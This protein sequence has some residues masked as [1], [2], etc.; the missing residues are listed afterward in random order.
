MCLCRIFEVF[1]YNVQ[2]CKMKKQKTLP[3][4]QK[5][6]ILAILVDLIWDLSNSKAC[7]SHSPWSDTFI[8]HTIR[9]RDNIWFFHSIQ[10]HNDTIFWPQK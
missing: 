6:K 7:W 1:F 2:G 4:S 9:Y 8:F 5:F 3:Q 10:Y